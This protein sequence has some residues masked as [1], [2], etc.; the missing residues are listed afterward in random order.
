MWERQHLKLHYVIAE[1]KYDE[2]T[3]SR[4]IKYKSRHKRHWKASDVKCNPYLI[5]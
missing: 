4:Y 3:T 2:I 5:L 1:K